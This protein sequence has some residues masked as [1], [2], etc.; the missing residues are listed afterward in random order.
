AVK[1]LQARR[2]MDDTSSELSRSMA[3]ITHSAAGGPVNTVRGAD[4]E[5][6][7]EPQNGR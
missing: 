4:S 3:A 1:R 5:L 2:V 7:K 6:F